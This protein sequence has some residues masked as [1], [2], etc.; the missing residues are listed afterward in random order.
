[1][2]EKTFL[3]CE[4]QLIVLENIGFPGK[5]QYNFS[6]EN[7]DFV[8][9]ADCG[10]EFGVL[11]KT[12]KPTPLPGAVFSLLKF[13]VNEYVF[14]EFNWFFKPVLLPNICSGFGGFNRAL[15]LSGTIVCYTSQV[16]NGC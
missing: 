16:T 3:R 8:I 11:I 4:F 5:S 13:S 6:Y 10:L 7:N 2:T 9:W 1:M 14:S 12:D 15:D